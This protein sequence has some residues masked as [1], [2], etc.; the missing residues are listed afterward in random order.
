[1]GN[2]NDRDEAR[3]K[4]LLNAV[5]RFL[6]DPQSLIVQVEEAKALAGA[7][8][9]GDPDVWRKKV[10]DQIIKQYALSAAVSGGV[11]S[12]PSTFPGMGSI[13]AATGGALLDMAVLLK[14]E[15]EMALCLS[16]LYGFDIRDEHERR[17]AFLLASVSTY[18]QG[19]GGNVFADLLEAETT[20]V[21]NYAPREVARLL[22]VVLARLAAR[23]TRR[24]LIKVVPV[25]GVLAGASVNMVLTRRVGRSMREELEQRA[26]DRAE[27]DEVVEAHVD[28][29]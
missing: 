28:E 1:M 23:M 27:Q 29:T 26:R 24:G 21:W 13:M 3:G 22:V 10:A 20:A 14:L 15:V 12:L 9:G 8:G 16:Y 11:T 2:E 4:I 19:H 18:E 7:P 17:I 6:S 5:E 25:V